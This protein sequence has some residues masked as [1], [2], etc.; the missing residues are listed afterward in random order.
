M[1]VILIPGRSLAVHD[2]ETGEKIGLSHVTCKS[3]KGFSTLTP[4][5]QDRGDVDQPISLAECKG[6]G[7]SSVWA[8]YFPSTIGRRQADQPVLHRLCTLKDNRRS[9]CISS[10]ICL[11]CLCWCTCRYA[12]GVRRTQITSLHRPL[13][14]A[15]GHYKGPRSGQPSAGQSTALLSQRKA[16]LVASQRLA[17][18]HPLQ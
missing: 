12:H 7:T 2:C 17:A 3:G 14:A 18:S 4:F 13:R 11:L 8:R 15:C 16:G 10:S 6:G 9:G 1:A 5:W